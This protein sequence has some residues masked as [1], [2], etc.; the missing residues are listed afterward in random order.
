MA[1]PPVNRRPGVDADIIQGTWVRGYDVPAGDQTLPPPS[2]C[3]L[4]ISNGKSQIDQ[5]L[6]NLIFASRTDSISQP[7]FVM[8]QGPDP[9]APDGSVNFHIGREADPNG[10]ITGVGPGALYSSYG[11]PGLWQLQAD[12]TTWI[13]ISD[14]LGGEDLQQTLAIGNTTGGFN[15]LLTNGDFL[16]GENSAVGAGADANI[17]G[18]NAT[19]GVGNGG[20]VLLQGGTSVAG[21]T[22]GITMNSPIATSSAGSGAF[23]ATTGDS[24]LGGP[25]GSLILRTGNAGGT[26]IAG[27]AGTL[28]LRAGR[29]SATGALGGGGRLDLIAGQATEEGRGGNVRLFSG[30]A[31]TTSQLYPFPLFVPGRAGDV[32]I[33]AG[34]S[35]SSEVGGSVVVRA[36]TGGS[37]GATGGGITLRPGV[38][39]GGFADGIV[40]AD[41]IFQADNI[42][43]GNGNPNGV[44]PGN[45]GDVYQRL[46]SGNGQ[47]WLNLN[48]TINGWSQ[49][50]LSGDFINSFEEMNWGYLC[51]AGANNGGPPADNLSANGTLEGTDALF[52]AG[53]T[54]GFGKSP[55]GPHFALTAIGG[56]DYAGV[57]QNTNST[58][59]LPYD[60]TQD[61]IITFRLRNE[62][63]QGFVFF[64]LS[65]QTVATHA[66]T[67]LVAGGNF[68]GFA[69]LGGAAWSI[70]SGNGLFTSSFSTGVLTSTT[71]GDPD[72]RPFFFVID[73]V[74]AVGG[75]GPV[76]FSIFDPDLVLLYSNAIT[77]TLPADTTPLGLVMS[78]RDVFGLGVFLQVASV[79]I[80][81]DAGNVAQGGGNGS[82]GNLALNQVLINGN[83]TGT[84]PILMNQGS[85][86][87][88]VIDDNLGDGASYGIFGG[89]T[90]LSTNNTGSVTLG[91]G[92]AFGGGAEDP[93]S[94]T[95]FVLASSGIQFGAASQGDTGLTT[96]WTGSHLGTDGTTGSVVIA[97]GFFT[98]GAAGTRTTGDI[99]IGPGTFAAGTATVNGEVIIKGGSSS[100]S[101]VTGGDVTLMSGE[102]AGATGNTGDILIETFDAN[103]SG[104]SGDVTIASGAGGTVAGD[105]GFISLITGPAVAGNTGNLF[106]ATQTAGNGTA[107]LMAMAIGLSSTGNGSIIS[108]VAGNTADALGV[109]GNI[110][111]TPGSG[112]AGDGEVVVNGKLNVTGLIDPTGLLLNGQAIVP[113]TVSAG[114]G[115]LWID[116]TGAPSKLIF[117]DDTNT[118]HDISTGGG[119][120]SLG[121][122]TDVTLTGPAPGEV[123]TFNGAD[124]VNLA[125]AGGSPFATILGI[126]NTTGA[127]PIVVSASLGS[128]ITSDGNLL[129]NPA[130]AVGNKVVID[131][132]SWPE[133]DGTAGY[134][135]T[136]NGLGALS[137]QPG[138]GGGGGPTFGEAFTRM[139][140]GT[141]Q[142]SDLPSALNADGILANFTTSSAAAIVA[143]SGPL[144]YVTKFVTA[145]AFGSSA[146]LE[147][148]Q[149]GPGLGVELGSFPIASFKFDGPDIGTSVRFFVGFTDAPTISGQTGAAVPLGTRYV[150]LQVYSDV[151]QTTLHF[152]TDDATG[153]PTYFNTG[154]SPVGLGFELVIDATTAGQIALSLYD[155]TGALLSSNAFGAN[156]PLATAKLGYQ[157]S[158][159]TTNAAAKTI[160]FYTGNMVTRGDLLSAAGG[161][162]G[163]QNLASVLG[164]GSETGGS[165]I[166]GDNNAAGSGSPLNLIG[167]NSTGGGGVGGDINIIPGIPDPGGIGG[168]GSI[169][170]ATV[171]GAGTGDGGDFAI[172]LGNGGPL[173]GDG[174][175]F[176]LS[177]GNGVG[178]GD[179]GSWIVSAGNSG[180]AGGAFA[181]AIGFTTGSGGVGSGATAGRFTF[182]A[183]VGDGSGDGGE[184]IFTAGNGGAAGGDGGGFTFTVGTGFGGGSDGVFTVTGDVSIS[185]KLT[186]A[187]MI[188]PPGLLMSSS[189]L[190]P[191]TP[192]GSEGGIWVNGAGELVYT[193]A[194]GDLNLST[195]IGGGM[196]FLDAMLTAGYGMLSAGNPSTG[197]DS[198]GVYGGS[199]NTAVSPGP[200]PASATFSEDTDGPFA[201]IA[202]AAAPLSEAF[203]GTADRLLERGSQFKSRFK[204]QVTSPAHT[205]E[206]IFIG[207]TD[208]PALVTPSAQLASDD[209]VAQQYMGIRQNLAGFNLEFVS[210]GS[211]G[212]MV[213]VFGLPTDALVHYLEVDASAATGDVTF[214]VYDADGV[215]ISGGG[216]ATHTEPAS[217]LLP[218]LALPLRPF[219][220]IHTATGTTPRGLDFYYTT[221]VTRADV[222]D[223]VTG[224]G[225]GGGT[226]ALG[227]V[228]AAGNTTGANGIEF[229][230]GNTGITTEAAAAG[231]ENLFI[232]AGDA[233]GVGNSAGNLI[234]EGGLW[235]GLPGKPGAVTIRSD[236]TG[237]L[238]A[239]GAVS[240]VGGTGVSGAGGVITV[241]TGEATGGQVTVTSGSGLAG[242]DGGG[243]LDLAAGDSWGT[244]DGGRV[245]IT[246]GDGGLGGGTGD[247]A[248]IILEA[249]A[250]VGT[251]DPGGVALL[252]GGA[253]PA[254]DGVGNIDLASTPFGGDITTAA[255]GIVGKAVSGAGGTVIL[256]AGS[257]PAASG[258]V[259]GDII[260]QTSLGD[261]AGDAGHIYLFGDG[262]SPASSVAP[263]G[264]VQMVGATD[265]TNGLG[266]AFVADGGSPISGG[267][268][269]VQG[270]AGI[271]GSGLT[272]G[273]VSVLGGAGD[274]AAAGGN[275][276]FTGGPG[277]ATG[278]GGDA[279]VRGGSATGGVNVGGDVRI[280]AGVGTG[281]DGTIKLE[282]KIDPAVGGGVAG[283]QFGV[284]PVVGAP[285]SFIVTFNT[286]FAAPPTTVTFNIESSAAAMAA[287]NNFSPTIAP[288]SITTTGFT[289]LLNFGVPYAGPISVHWVAYA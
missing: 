285:A 196:T 151:P 249:G 239:S 40:N 3:D 84:L 166:S 99:L 241:K 28:Q 211:G 261:G 269:L 159:T 198:Y 133:S 220:G 37:G 70:V 206:R 51:L 214:T 1:N 161:G 59:A 200:P 267:I 253:T 230:I 97:T 26:G 146:G 205:D 109:G 46:N 67:P 185:G 113:A 69:M 53:G 152:V 142:S 89:A 87:F 164:F 38:G 257:A 243:N 274:G 96:I 224:S 47:L 174:G 66:A 33:T 192:V 86:L 283:I 104:D 18:G 5:T 231:G 71:A 65:N 177:T 122:L 287:P 107:G 158:A 90:T 186:V 171:P 43:R 125:G 62:N 19:G 280:A 39:G 183:G 266:A 138:G 35:S 4:I 30:N 136:T 36:G 240:L 9:T 194:G 106:L 141:V 73:A 11:T 248:P 80:V 168:A 123:L 16:K 244:A 289:V 184:H 139:Q 202:V 143:G 103:L 252:A 260:L 23:N 119:A 199:V 127:L 8:A 75:A 15:I 120:T 105:S 268:A 79:S 78:N 148:E 42:K 129:L 77:T 20:Q 247:G 135:L 31:T 2:P 275:V 48:G 150:G 162:G 21:V 264:D 204:F 24:L 281:G 197:P 117:T 175:G 284:F 83:E 92:N 176:S 188:D 262:A 286:A 228:L 213:P 131:G 22:G 238:G 60:L 282:G 229:S 114:D 14:D 251:G 144:G 54:I 72:D 153:V 32:E 279:T 27:T 157:Y 226:P 218:D 167:G 265:P 94:S 134:V 169:L 225:G 45:E 272:G 245:T 178:V 216:S 227:L 25:S 255:Y 233:G 111:L 182:I 116:S 215:T 145:A 95:G 190:A 193:N 115:L 212:A 91:S 263:G 57:D 41:G 235:T 50:A 191:F 98:N 273:I 173:G 130:V 56:G 110:E 49:M 219:F 88:G 93:G 201:N 189:G 209:P 7:I 288:G 256:Q 180:T 207:F 10:L 234:L 232:S 242:N 102:A 124:W 12:D 259:G 101:G 172:T 195:A 165:P 254:S 29:S 208:D 55:A 187:G 217:L 236:S 270:G 258:G 6:S 76:R 221:V 137:F 128:S 271:V 112:P 85:G 82:A 170:M 17:A 118:D 160:G 246:A 108:M 64:G 126:G 132:I 179:G 52:S 181:G 61:N 34:S 154:V 277:G 156:L 63:P 140:W 222:V 155:N 44:V 74:D 163:N 81:A 68:F 100:L 149:T 276:A 250:P 147:V 58:S 203:I 278:D 210:R 223:A 13:Q 237:P 121:A